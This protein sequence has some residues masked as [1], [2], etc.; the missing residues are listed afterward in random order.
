MS[1]WKILLRLS[2]GAL[3]VWFL[4]Y[5]H[6]LNCAWSSHA[7]DMRLW[8][9]HRAW[10]RSRWPG[11]ERVALGKLSLGGRPANFRDVLPVYFSGMFFNM[12][13]PTSIGGDVF[14]VVGL[15]RKTGSKPAPRFHGPQRASPRCF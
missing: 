11:I 14:R 2:V 8:A 4:L 7:A 12:C 5:K 3:L 15:G 13:L 9:G 1:I 6:E 10:N